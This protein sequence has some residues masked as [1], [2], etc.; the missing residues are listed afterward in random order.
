MAILVSGC[1]TCGGAWDPRAGNRG[2]WVSILGRVAL[3]GNAHSYRRHSGLSAPHRAD[4][5]RL[6]VHRRPCHLRTWCFHARAWRGILRARSVRDR[7]WPDRPWG[8]FRTIAANHA[9][10]RRVL[11]ALLSAGDRDFCWSTGLICRRPTVT[12]GNRNGDN[13]RRIRSAGPRC[14]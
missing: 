5:D 9:Q 8:T 11:A 3:A 7:A 12:S 13:F 4:L 1:C 10:E 14:V 2:V 6:R